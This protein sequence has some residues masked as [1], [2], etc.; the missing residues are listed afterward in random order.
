MRQN[1]F[2]F[3]EEKLGVPPDEAI[4]VWQKAFAKY[5]QTLKGLRESGFVFDTEQYWD[6]IR[7]G[8]E[9]FL[10]PDPMVSSWIPSFH[11]NSGIKTGL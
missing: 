4:P 5:N 1:V 3:M 9:D 7:A 11:S 8:A 2:K 10:R 6:Y